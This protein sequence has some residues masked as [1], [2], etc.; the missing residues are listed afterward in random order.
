MADGKWIPGLQADLP[1]VAAARHVLEVRLQAVRNRLPQAV[2][3][4]DEDVEHVHQLR[5]S[6]R[7]AGAAL[8]IFQDLLPG[9]VYDRVR[10]KLRKVRRAAGAARD[11]DVF[12]ESLSARLGKIASNQKPGLDLLIG[13]AHGQRMAAQ[14]LLV[15]ATQEPPLELDPVVAEALSSLRLPDGM[16]AHATLRD[17]AVPQLTVLLHDLEEA[18]AGDLNDYEHL[19]QVRILGKRMRYAMEVFESCFDKSF[20]E[21]HYPRVEE[22]QDILGKAN[23]SHVAAQKLTALAERL[24]K[25][26]GDRWKRYRPGIVNLLKHHQ[27]RL[28]EQRDLFVAWWERWRSSGGEESFAQILKNPTVSLCIPFVEV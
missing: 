8:R 14:P 21:V 2:F 4:A 11:W 23:D 7:R 26:Q 24:E 1:A 5:V 17:L 6:T 28:P 13:L 3:Q 15:M 16:P 20:R 18:A 27:K 22:M 10:K 12:L 25:V 9:K 19:H